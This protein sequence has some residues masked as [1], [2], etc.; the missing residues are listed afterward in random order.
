MSHRRHFLLICILLLSALILTSCD[1]PLPG[2]TSTPP[3]CSV[4]FLRTAINDANSN[5]PG[6][7][8]IDLDPGCIYELGSVDNTIDGNNGLPSLT[9]SMIINGNGATIRRSTGAQKA[10]IR[11]LHISPGGEL[12]L[13]NIILLDGMGME[14]PDVTDPTRNSGGAI[15]NAGTLTVNDSLITDNH[16]KM[17]GG[18]IFNAG[19]M[20]LTNS[21]IQNNGVNIGNEP[22]ESGG[23]ISN[24]GTATLT[25]CT[26]ADNIASQSAA[27][28]ANSGTMTITNSTL[29][30][31]TTTLTEIA[32]GAA[33]I[34]AGTMTISFTT[35]ANNAGTSSGA[36][37]SAPDTIQISSSLIANNAPADCS[38]P[39]TSPISGE[40][41]DSDGSCVGFTITDDPL[42]GPLADNGGPTQT[43][44]LDALSPAADAA[45]GSCPA[46]DQRGEP[47]PQG[48]ACDLG[49]VEISSLPPAGTSSLLEGV[50]FHDQDADGAL[51]GGE[52]GLDGVELTLGSGSC[53]SASPAWTATSAA[54]GSY[55]LEIPPPSAGSYC[56]SIDPLLPPNDTI[57]IPGDFTDPAGGAREI[58]LT[59]GEDLANMNFAWDFQFAG[60]QGA[61][62]VISNV[63][64]SADTVADGDWVEVEVT[65]E[66][67]GTDTASGYELVLI[68]HYGVGPPNPAGY[69][70]LPDLASGDS[71]TVTFSPGVIYT[72]VG[73][74]TLRVLVTNDWYAL[75]DPDS[76]G[77]A[78][79][80]QDFTITVTGPDLVI[81]SVDL[82]N[83]TLLPDQ[84][85]E[86]E[87]TVENQGAAVASG[88][89]AVLIPHY[90]VGPP[91]PAGYENIPD[92]SPGQSHTLTFSPGVIY[93]AVGSYTLRV[94]VSDTWLDS[95]DPDST[96]PFGDTH[97]TAITVAD[98]CGMFRNLDITMVMLNVPADTLALPIYF[99]FPEAVPGPEEG[100]LYEY[101]ARLGKI[102]A[103]R[104]GLQG[105]EDRLYCM[106]QLPEDAPGKV[107][108]LEL[109][110]QGCQDPI[111]IE[112][113]V[114][115][116][117]PKIE[118][119]KDLDAEACQAAGGEMST[120]VTTA[121][122]C[123][124]P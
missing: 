60:A 102:E 36:V 112:K 20:T 89:D 74:H 37:F 30:G 95:G 44:S 47:R 31:N 50:V 35:I 80:Y 72:G 34:N 113:A 64:L 98:H 56:L 23:G 57:L 10:A 8:T 17:K 45:A 46:A 49:A 118:C 103:Y 27:G 1:L 94:L 41:L 96:G 48:A 73:D 106:F 52:P 77:T 83:T 19:T 92:L 108:P 69:E 21:T 87:V 33:L 16:A 59:E 88:F 107:V 7:D 51:D 6:T 99:K 13:N 78:G 105:F 82:D 15:Y 116:P 53:P 93:P 43:H 63:D 38:Y 39:A 75:G 91:N 111:F 61:D 14:P 79:D 85:M 71:H 65:L 115:I 76:T 123:I 70:P 90:G 2:G 42:L 121:P 22:G 67:Q 68:P 9:T 100:E 55:Q 28:I 97:N 29:S 3:P 25:G 84:F 18:G 120:G 58:T 66:N 122:Y 26:I 40:N 119:T 109:N 124:C 101:G 5:G 86:V 117:V 32:S 81:T 11:L 24:T 62:L 114:R 110:L 54:D 4:D 104:C 12:V